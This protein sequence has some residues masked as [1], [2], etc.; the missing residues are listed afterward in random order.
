MEKKVQ[1]NFLQALT[2][3]DHKLNKQYLQ[4]MKSFSF[5]EKHPELYT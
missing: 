2:P 5:V 4:Y 1:I 3:E